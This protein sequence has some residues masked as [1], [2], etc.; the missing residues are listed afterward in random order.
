VQ[1]FFC[2][3]YRKKT[4]N[5]ALTGRSWTTRPLP[6]FKALLYKKFLDVRSINNDICLFFNKKRILA[7]TKWEI[8]HKWIFFFRILKED[9][10]NNIRKTVILTMTIF[11]S[12]VRKI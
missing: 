6:A 4:I 2:S 1:N 5:F 9:N 7:K 11:S 12:N 3:T 8:C 10:L